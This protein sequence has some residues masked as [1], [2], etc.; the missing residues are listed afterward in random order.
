MGL[1]SFNEEHLPQSLKP[2][3][4]FARGEEFGVVFEQGDRGFDFLD[5][6]RDS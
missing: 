3:A 5:V 2:A 1:T 6:L 4:G